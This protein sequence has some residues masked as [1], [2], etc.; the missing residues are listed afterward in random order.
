M[1]LSYRIV[2]P[3][4]LLIINGRRPGLKLNGVV[5]PENGIGGRDGAFVCS[6]A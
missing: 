4:E 3:V 5:S 6:A 1:E 2:C